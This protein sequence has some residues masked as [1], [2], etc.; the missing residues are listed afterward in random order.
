MSTAL[1]Q[2]YRGGLATAVG[3]VRQGL[4]GRT[5]A[6]DS[7]GETTLQHLVEVASLEPW[8][9]SDGVEHWLPFLGQ[10]AQ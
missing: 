10:A 4:K 7:Y 2:S 8:C 5:G 3:G 9:D 1:S 6:V